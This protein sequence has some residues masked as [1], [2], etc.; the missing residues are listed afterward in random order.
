VGWGLKQVG[1]EV[2]HR[3]ATVA[4]KRHSQHTFCTSIEQGHYASIWV[5]MGAGLEWGEGWGGG[6]ILGQTIYIWTI[7]VTIKLPQNVTISFCYISIN[8]SYII[9][10]KS[11]IGVFLVPL[12]V[13]GA[14]FYPC[15][16]WVKAS[17]RI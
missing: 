13:A 5:G 14:S 9:F 11:P 3:A 2:K 8:C 15:A 12:S 17:D 10:P 16:A 7:F 6:H 1:C 4:C